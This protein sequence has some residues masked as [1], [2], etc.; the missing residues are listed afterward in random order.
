MNLKDTK[1]TLICI[2]SFMVFFRYSEV[3][4]LRMSDIFHE[5]YMAIL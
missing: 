1:L 4:N 5:S 2:F 3:S